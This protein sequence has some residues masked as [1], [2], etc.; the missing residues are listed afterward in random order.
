MN[1]IV[2]AL[3]L[4]HDFRI[5]LLSLSNIK[6]DA[7]NNNVNKEKM[8]LDKAK[9]D[10]IRDVT[11]EIQRV[12][13]H[14]KHTK[15]QSVSTRELVN[16]LPSPWTAGR[17]QDASE[18]AKYLLDNIWETIRYCTDYSKY[19]AVETHIDP[20]FGGVQQNNIKCSRCGNISSKQESFTEVALSMSINEADEQKEL[21][22]TKMIEQHFGVEVLEG[23]NKYFC[24]KCND[25]VEAQRF[26]EIVCP[27]KHLIICFKRFSWNYETMKRVKKNDV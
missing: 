20:L 17:Q 13:G 1:S 19:H 27:P 24:E 6:Y 25:K 26:T 21:C 16:L 8:K 12:F 5:K 9:W 3:Y 18:F 22:T 11:Q 10:K 15:E 4:S 2:Q 23:D 14:L 7:H